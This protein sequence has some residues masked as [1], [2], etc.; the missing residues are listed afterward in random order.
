MELSF[1]PDT[2]F[3]KSANSEDSTMSIFRTIFKWIDHEIG[4]KNID[5]EL[6]AGDLD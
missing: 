3:I 1:I 6:E 2:N 5:L 4:I